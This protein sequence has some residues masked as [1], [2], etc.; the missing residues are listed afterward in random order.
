MKKTTSRNVLHALNALIGFLLFMGGFWFV[1]TITISIMLFFIGLIV[2]L[3]LS[4]IYEKYMLYGRFRKSVIVLRSIAITVL[5]LA[6]FAPITLL[7]FKNTKFMY[8]IKRFCYGYGAY[9]TNF[10]NDILPSF[11]PKKC[12]NYMFITQ[13]SVLAQDYRPSAYLA[14]HTDSET[15]KKYEEHF[16]SVDNTER[17]TAHMSDKEEKTNFD[18]YKISLKCPEKLPLDVFQHLEPEHI[19]DFKNAII[20]TRY[21]SGCMLDY[22]SG[23]AVFWY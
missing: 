19:H 16:N 2:N 4:L 3:A 1:Y 8:P 15:L 17:H 18:E 7:K 14:F 22:D 10:N 5:A 23:L 12:D 6:V 11:L 20:Y 13:G 9:S 21:G